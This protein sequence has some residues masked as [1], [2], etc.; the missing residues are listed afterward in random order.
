MRKSFSS[1]LETFLSQNHTDRELEKGRE[2]VGEFVNRL[3]TDSQ[4]MG[5]TK[6]CPSSKLNCHHAIGLALTYLN[7]PETFTKMETVA[8]HLERLDKSDL[9]EIIYRIVPKKPMSFA[10]VENAISGK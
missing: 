6:D 7:F 9:I 5:A 4:I 2:Y 1:V 8:S 3:T 10:A